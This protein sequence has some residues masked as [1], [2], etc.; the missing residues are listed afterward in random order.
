MARLYAATLFLSAL[1]LFSVQPLVAR[2]L[3]PSLGGTAVVWNTAMVFFQ[4]VL[5]LGYLWAHYSLRWFG[6]RR[7]RWLHVALM[8]GAAIALPIAI[9]PSAEAADAPL[10]WLIAR[11][12]IAVFLPF[13]AMAAIAPMLQRWFARAD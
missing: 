10:T 5:L 11:L 6:M 1:L 4:A 2:M 9:E 8:V 7:Q 13:F 12:G 3:L